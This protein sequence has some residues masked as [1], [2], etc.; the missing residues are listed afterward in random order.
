MLN[1]KAQIGETITWVVATIIIIVVL[2]F[3]IFIAGIY[4]EKGKT[5]ESSSLESKDVL[6]SKSLFS[7]LLTPSGE[8]KVYDQ[9]KVEENLNKS[10]G[11]LAQKIFK[12]LYETDYEDIWL[13]FVLDR[14]LLSAKSNDYFGSKPLGVRGGDISFGSRF[15]S[16]ISEEIR[17]NENKSLEL[18]LGKESSIK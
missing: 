10:T 4:F 3:S 12:E 16:R 6:A 13:G 15:V 17:L 2:V 5:L 11:E 18:Y 7:Y 9:L 1:K 8:G 14:V